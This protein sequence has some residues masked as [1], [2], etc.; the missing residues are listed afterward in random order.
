[1]REVGRTTPV[2]ANYPASVKEA[3]LV[4]LPP[5]NGDSPSKPPSPA[6]AIDTHSEP[7]NF[8]T[9]DNFDS[10]N[11]LSAT[12]PVD[13]SPVAAAIRAPSSTVLT[14][15]SFDLSDPNPSGTPVAKEDPHPD[16][17]LV[18]TGGTTGDELLVD[19]IADIPDASGL[20]KKDSLDLSGSNGKR[21]TEAV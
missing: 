9:P 6:P 21:K 2:Q 8:Q 4:P 20:R 18:D 1:M 17:R 19:G 10:Q 12:T 16:V 13:P 11:L 5:S 7:Q 14:P 15:T 3:T